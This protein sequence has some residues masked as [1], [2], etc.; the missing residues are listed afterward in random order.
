MENDYSVIQVC[1]SEL[2]AKCDGAVSIDGA[3]FNKFDTEIG[4]QL[5]SGDLSPKQAIVAQRIVIKYSGQLDPEYVDYVRKQVIEVPETAKVSSEKISLV[6]DEVINSLNWSAPK[7]V[8]N[9]TLKLETADPDDGFEKFYKAN[10]SEIR[11]L[12]ISVSNKFGRWQV[13][14]WTPIQ[15]IKETVGTNGFVEQESDDEWNNLEIIPSDVREKLHDYQIPSVLRL[16]KSLALNGAALDA[17]DGGTGKTIV[18]IAVA[19]TLSK[20][21]IVCCP[22]SIKSGW[23]Y[24]AAEFGVECFV[25]NYEQYKAGN[26]EFGR[27]VTNYNN[28][29]EEITFKWNIP[30]DCILIF[31]E[32]HRCGSLTSQNS[33]LLIGAAEA[34]KDGT[35]VLACSATAAS[36]PLGMRGL[37]YL[38]G[39]FELNN[40]WTWAQKNGCFKGRWAMEFSG[41]PIH[42]K[43]IHAQIFPNNGSRVRISEVPNF[44]DSIISPEL[45]DFGCNP[46]IQAA[47]ET[48]LWE[49]EKLKDRCDR[50]LGNCIL[51]TIL[52]ARMKVELLKIPMIADMVNDLIDDG[53]SVV[54]FLSFQD[55]IDS[56]ASKLK[57]FDSV[58]DGKNTG[59][60]RDLVVKNFQENKNRVIICNIKAGSE[61]IGLH[62]LTGEF[63]RVTLLNPD[64]SAVSVKQALLRTPRNG[65]KTACVQ[66]FLFADGTI[67]NRARDRVKAK[68]KNIS[69]LN[70]GDLGMGINI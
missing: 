62:D 28:G 25:E 7:I 3:G 22:K 13:C 29:K 6:F 10:K 60:Q 61:A 70:D 39:L 48:M 11:A 36:S 20:K 1:L 41:N 43:N 45:I 27:W 67:E 42:L 30:D 66:K 33:E 46:K 56:L 16:V 19:K 24:W 17:S 34:K 55:S 2:A 59:S 51:V 9:G 38:L 5:S 4:R 23:K 65:G 12:G 47:Y 21:A 64:F 32:S 40:F 31:D 50:D 14:R 49:I 35:K 54:V 69:T 15:E 57:C 53:N 8:K 58:V 18:G 44:P 63:P 68:I 26:T 37:G 52:R